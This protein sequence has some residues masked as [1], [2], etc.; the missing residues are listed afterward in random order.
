M[1][2]TARMAEASAHE[3]WQGHTD[4]RPWMLRSLIAMFRRIDIRCLYGVMAVVVVFYMLFN[5]RGYRAIRDLFRRRLGYG[6]RQTLRAVYATHYRFGQ[7]ILDR[8]AVYA[9][10]RFEVE[11]EHNEYYR[12]LV[13]RPGG[14]IMV[15]S[16]VG[17][18]ELAGYSLHPAEKRFYALVYAGE[19]ETV[20]QNRAKCFAGNNIEMVPVMGDMSHL[21][22]AN[23]AL[24]EG[25]IVGMPGDRLF[26]SQKSVQCDFLGA[27]ARFPLGPFALAVQR[28]V[29]M[30]SIFVMKE[31]TKRYRIFVDRIDTGDVN[32]PKRLRMEYAAR[33][34]A[35]QL[36]RIV[37]RYPT[38]WF[39][40]YNFW[41]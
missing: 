23:R 36:E 8:F 16:H 20:M 25:N 28:E 7:V 5:R 30:L 10:Q 13:A 29:P 31:A 17:N 15:S 24:M 37:R 33:S 21:F 41:E 35:A 3:A 1:T 22:V 27:S 12:E 14:F 11:I 2:S 26:G 39:N 6:R 32:Q 19:K 18:Y 4:G 40:F 34:F 9:G 38:Q